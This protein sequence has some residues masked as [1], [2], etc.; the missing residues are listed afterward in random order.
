M[1]K[2]KA[3]PTAG[4]PTL[5][6]KALSCTHELYLFI[7]FLV[8]QST[9]LS[10]RTVDG[11]Q[12]YFGGWVVHVGIRLQQLASDL[13][14]PSPNHV[15]IDVRSTGQRS[16]S[17]LDITYHRQKTLKARKSCPRSNLVKIIPEPSATRNVVFNVIRSKTVIAI[18]PP[19]I[20]R[21]RSNLVQSFI[22]SQDIHCKMLKVKGQRS[23]C[24]RSKLQ[25]K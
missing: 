9:V 5:F 8:Y 1:V 12:M 13:A 6:E 3:F 21:L 14:R 20:A 11:H 17:Q 18:T 22:S 7:Y 19:Q 4:R 10:S 25:V 24:R 23:Q 15:T 2:L 16:R